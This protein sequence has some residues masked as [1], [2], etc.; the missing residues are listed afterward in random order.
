MPF[1]SKYY[2]LEKFNLGDGW[3]RETFAFAVEQLESMGREKLLE[4]MALPYIQLSFMG[5]YWRE[6]T[7]EEEF[8]AAILSDYKQPDVLQAIYEVQN[9]TP[10]KKKQL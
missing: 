10:P 7:P 3:T 2:N 9:F 8:V 5:D 4:L 1:V 6:E